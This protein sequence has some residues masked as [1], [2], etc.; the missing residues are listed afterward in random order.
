MYSAALKTTNAIAAPGRFLDWYPEALSNEKDYFQSLLHRLA[1]RKR[2]RSM[3]FS[4][5]KT[6]A[7]Q[8]DSGISEL[9]QPENEARRDRLNRIRSSLRCNGF[10]NDNLVQ[11]FALVGYEVR[12]LFG[13]SLHHEQYFCAWS[14]LHGMLAEM[15]TGEGKSITAALASI[16]AALA[17]APVHVITTNDYLVERDATSMRELFDRFGL[18]SSYALA[19]HGDDERRDAYSHDICY[20]SNKQLVFDYL[21]DRQQLGN[22]PSSISGRTQ[23]LFQ[24]K[25][26]EPLLRGLC[27]AIVDEADSVLIDDAITPLILSREAQGEQVFAQSLTAISLARRLEIGVDFNVDSRARRITVTE[28]GE[29]KLSTLASSLNGTWKNRRFRLELIRQALSAIHLFHR[30]KDYLLRDNA[31]VLVDQSTGRVM[32]DR[33]LQHGLHQMVEMKEKCALTGL[34]ETLS[35]L[36]FQTFFQRYKHLCGMTGTA[37]EAVAELTRVYQL[38]VVTVPQH[39]PS[40]RTCETARFAATDDDHLTLLLATVQQSV[41][42]GQPVL[43]GTR[44]VAASERIGSYLSSRQLRVQILNARQDETE[45]QLVARAGDVGAVTIATNIAGRGTDIPLND[46]V[47]ALGGLKVVVAELNDSQRVDRQLIGRGARQGDPGAYVYVISLSDEMLQ[48]YA[49][50]VILSFLKSKASRILPLW[51]RL[52][53]SLCRYVQA[54]HEDRQEKL[55]KQV[56]LA[57]VELQK[58]LSFTGYKE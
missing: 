32:P 55:R 24:V 20:V 43:V 33:K 34:A 7:A 29:T 22:R 31:V 26:P 6:I 23:G 49:P 57:D 11:A 4:R 36:S 17:G 16:V 10:E 56:S 41:D 50:K 30:D 39:R 51:H 54:K 1:C 53:F 3:R 25:V 45:A 46:E 14:L 42:L 21:R 19:A 40:A 38:G 47:K 28:Q 48:R 13:F 15:A 2:A 35:S 58:R 44:S 27:F 5:F 8:I 12:E 37:K 9:H 18:S 52:C